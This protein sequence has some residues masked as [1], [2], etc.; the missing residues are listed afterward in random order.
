VYEVHESAFP[1]LPERSRHIVFLRVKTDYRD[2]KSSRSS[3]CANIV[4]AFDH[5][6]D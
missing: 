3:L 6:I 2:R 4:Q 1:A 5:L